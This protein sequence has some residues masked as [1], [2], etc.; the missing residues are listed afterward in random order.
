PLELKDIKKLST[1]QRY[2]YRI[3]LAVKD[4][5]LSSSVTENSPGELSHARWLTS[6]NR[7]LRLNIGTPSPSQNLIMLV[8]KNIRELTVWNIL[9]SRD[10]KTKNS[11][12]LRF[13][14]LAKLN[15]EAADYA[16]IIDWSNCVVTES[17]LTMTIKDKVLKE[18]FKEEHFPA[19]TFEEFPCPTQSVEPS[20]KLISEAAMKVCEA[21]LYYCHFLSFDGAVVKGSILFGYVKDAAHATACYKS[22]ECLLTSSDEKKLLVPI[23]PCHWNDGI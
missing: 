10:K 9:G 23:L 16:D 5:S 21:K 22:R 17:P 7:F 15:F 3:S 13:L 1:D 11:G 2:L 19:V 18:M 8:K 20:V 14:E 4:D 12:G 6:A